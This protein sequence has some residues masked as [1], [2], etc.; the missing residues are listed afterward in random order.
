MNN[1]DKKTEKKER[2]TLVNLSVGTRDKLAQIQ[3]FE[4]VAQK[5]NL[6]LS[7]IFELLVDNYLLKQPNI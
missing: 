5:K 7:Q 6:T 1:Q 4:Q 3:G 2:I